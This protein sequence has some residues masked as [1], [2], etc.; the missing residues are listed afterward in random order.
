MKKGFT[1]AEVLIILGIIGIVAAMTIPTL[2]TTHQKKAAAT[3]LKEAY[4]IL[5]NAARMANNDDELVFNEPKDYC[6]G[7]L[8]THDIHGI[9]AT[10]F[11]PYLNGSTIKKDRFSWNAKTPAGEDTIL[12]GAL[13]D[14]CYSLNN[15][16]C[17][18]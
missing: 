10:Y 5:T 4:A 11:A 2:I 15:G 7:G 3:Q 12:V 1:L 6:K 16:M 18:V 8:E 13:G 17:S 14:E 9:F